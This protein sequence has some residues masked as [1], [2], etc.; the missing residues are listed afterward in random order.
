MCFVFGALYNSKSQNLVPN[1]SF[2]IDTACPSG[3]SNLYYAIPWFVP[4]TAWSSTDLF[5]SCD[6]SITTGSG[7][8]YNDDGYQWARTG[9][10]YA[11][12]IV[13]FDTINYREYL[14]IPLLNTL[15]A[16]RNYCVEFY[17]SLA[18]LS[19]MAISDLGAYFSND[20]LLDSNLYHAIDY[21]TPQRENPLGN[22]LSDTSNWMLVSGNFI[23]NGG[24]RFITI[25]N[26]HN[27][28]NT[29]TQIGPNLNPNGTAY[30]YIDDVSV[31]DCTEIGIKEENKDERITVYPNPNKGVFEVRTDKLKIKEIEIFNVIGEK[32]YIE[33]IKDM[34]I[35]TIN[36][37][38]KPGLY[39]V[40]VKTENGTLRKK[41]VVQ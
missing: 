36:I 17:V 20:S 29:S 35:A 6:N 38:T 16:N 26:F 30:Y 41:I 40:Q 18:E 23:A 37:I 13:Y 15:I 33:E 24:E 39:F 3:S 8:P 7:V 5:D 2:E 19:G 22:M 10:K 9:V 31:V 1:Y 4:H 14:E 21:V 11:G 12:I 27:P 34:N 25:G 32:I 28:A